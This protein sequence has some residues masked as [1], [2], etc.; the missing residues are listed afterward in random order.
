MLGKQVFGECRI[1]SR[2]CR[3]QAR[4]L[5]A[6]RRD[7]DAD[8]PDIGV[9]GRRFEDDQ[10]LAFFDHFPFPDQDFPDD[11]AFQ[12]LD[13]LDLARR[14]DFAHGRADDVENAV[15]GPDEESG[16]G[17]QGQS[18]KQV[19]RLADTVVVG[20]ILVVAVLRIFGTDHG[21]YP[22]YVP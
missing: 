14:D 7:V 2:R 11:A 18:E 10:G 1:C 12:V 13:A 15:R 4:D 6:K 17:G 8:L 5:Q 3:L 22:V 16:A 9:A 21:S 19:R 20:A